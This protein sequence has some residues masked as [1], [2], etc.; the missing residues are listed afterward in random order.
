MRLTQQCF[1]LAVTIALLSL[2]VCFSFYWKTNVHRLVPLVYHNWLPRLPTQVTVT[3]CSETNGTQ[4]STVK[5][6]KSFS[7]LPE[8]INA[9][10]YSHGNHTMV[11]MVTMVTDVEKLRRRIRF[12]ASE[13]FYVLHKSALSTYHDQCVR[14]DLVAREI[15]DRFLVLED[16]VNQ[17][18][19]RHD[20]MVKNVTGSSVAFL[21][22]I[23]NHLHTLR[24]WTNDSLRFAFE[25]LQPS[26]CTDSDCS[27]QW[28]SAFR[29][30]YRD[31]VDLLDTWESLNEQLLNTTARTDA[32]QK[33]L[34]RR[35]S[36]MQ[37]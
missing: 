14:F 22:T 16:C 28:T 34:F 12:L 23:G 9:K 24:R 26:L 27:V 30:R 18:V 21:V 35:W 25:D 17:A 4:N 20:F 7:Q 13:L 1:A 19:T 29:T 8:P 2:S 36:V 5:P 11:T 31:L 10:V 6:P 37:V 3:N 33:K 32:L 15:R